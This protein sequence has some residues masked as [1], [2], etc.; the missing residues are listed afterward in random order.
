MS[1][2]TRAAFAVAPLGALASA[3][4]AFAQTTDFVP[5]TDEMLQNP[6]PADWLMWRRTLDSWGHSPLDQIDTGNVASLRLVFGRGRSGPGCRKARRSSMTG[7][8][9]SRIRAM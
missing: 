9:T 1:M 7:S 4:T 5:V 8:C 2:L 6:D 3:L